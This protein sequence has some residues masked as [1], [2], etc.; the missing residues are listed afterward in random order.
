MGVDKYGPAD[1]ATIC[2]SSS[3]LPHA[4]EHG[5]VGYFEQNWIATVM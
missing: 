5:V 3:S 4:A 2:I 1:S